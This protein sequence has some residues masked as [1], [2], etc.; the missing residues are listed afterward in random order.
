MVT[1][2]DPHWC[3]TD[4]EYDNPGE[5]GNR[6]DVGLGMRSVFFVGNSVLRLEKNEN[7]SGILAANLPTN[8]LGPDPR[9]SSNSISKPS[10]R[11]PIPGR[12]SIQDH[13]CE[14]YQSHIF[15]LMTDPPSH[16]LYPAGSSITKTNFAKFGESMADNN[17]IGNGS[18]GRE[19][20][21]M[22]TRSSRSP[23]QDESETPVTLNRAV[24]EGEC[25]R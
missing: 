8:C 13:N 23:R 7:S 1:N 16:K 6:S 5:R 18:R 9:A 14:S 17:S 3:H 19:K 21:Y 4:R 24:W 22:E 2:G 11:S 20:L 10:H 12:F 15:L 25:G